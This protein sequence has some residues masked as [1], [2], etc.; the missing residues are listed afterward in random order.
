MKYD[1]PF[2][3]EL[4]RILILSSLPVR[5]LFKNKNFKTLRKQDNSPLTTADL[6]ANKILETG[7]INLFPKAYYLSEESP[8]STIRFTSDYLWI[9]D[10]I[11]GTREFG[12][13]VPEYS[14]SVGLV[15]RKRPVT[16]II[17]IPEENTLVLNKPDEGVIVYDLDL[18][19]LDQKL[20]DIVDTHKIEYIENVVLDMLNIKFD[21]MQ[22][23]TSRPV[24]NLKVTNLQKAKI[25][26]SATEFRDGLF[27]PFEKSGMSFE[28]TGSIAR[29]LALLACGKADLVV[30]LR[31]KN[32]WDICAGHALVNAIPGFRMTDLRYFRDQKYNQF[33]LNN[34]GLVAGPVDLVNKF[35]NY[36]KSIRSE[37]SDEGV[38]KQNSFDEGYHVIY[39]GSS[40]GIWDWEMASGFI[41]F[42]KKWSELLFYTEDEKINSLA[43]WNKLI[44]SDDVP[45]FEK[46]LE[47]LKNK[48]TEYF[49]IEYRM[50][51][52]HGEYKW[53]RLSGCGYYDKNDNLKRIGGSQ[54]DITEDKAFDPITGLPNRVLFQDRLE[55]SFYRAKEIQEFYFS[56]VLVS[57]DRFGRLVDSL[58]HS[59]VEG[60]MQNLAEHLRKFKKETDTLARISQNEFVFLVEDALDIVELSQRISYLPEMI[61]RPIQHKNTKIIL[62]ASIGFSIYEGSYRYPLQMLK[63][64]T[65]AKNRVQKTGGNS[66][67]LY[68]HSMVDSSSEL[69]EREMDLHVAI[70]EKQMKLYYQPI[71][72]G[73]TLKLVGFE[74]LVRWQHPGKG[75]ISPDYFIALSEE[76]GLIIPL[77]DFILE[78]AF[79]KLN[80]FQNDLKLDI[81]VSV[82]LSARQLTSNEMMDTF[83]RLIKKYSIDVT[84]LKLEITESVA[85]HSVETTISLL[86][87]L[88]KLGIGISIDDFGTGYSSLSY[89]KRLP[90]STMKIDKSFIVDITKDEENQVIV[91]AIIALAE[92][93]ELNVIVEGVEKKEQLEMLQSW[94]HCQYQG[95][96]FGKA[97]PPEDLNDYLLTHQSGQVS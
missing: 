67:Q 75:L 31:P 15:Y 18:A 66:S 74:A 29:K 4:I 88:N 37:K 79:I 35:N 84:K 86:N 12:N 62:S 5:Y 57:I 64:A 94:G 80:E 24:K 71:V 72:D 9:V 96:Y 28:A 10:P 87:H 59:V 33:N 21:P 3:K 78:Q 85:M 50:L 8:T 27:T 52:K 90:L 13:H 73:I 30:S 54:L 65:I 19:E 39:N 42:N 91:Q 61:G 22:Y 81:F 14:I 34:F 43:E 26:V 40:V 97:M 68:N 83:T 20:Y 1:E 2:F 49:E 51:N 60:I 77:G 89:L 23:I 36:Y 76:T 32:E 46:S 6:V 82:N 17:V 11:D 56:V 41:H 45:L 70:R 69:F 63:D 92:K 93:L 7:L 58:G 53:M 44:H 95:F 38:K 47:S 16:G 25:L 48:L 55:H